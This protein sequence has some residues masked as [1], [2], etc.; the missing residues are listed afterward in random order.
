MKIKKVEEIK[1]NDKIMAYEVTVE[2]DGE[3]R[4]ECFVDDG[5][6]FDLVDGEEKF[7]KQ[8]K[9]NKEK[10]NNKVEEEPD[11]VKTSIK[12]FEDKVI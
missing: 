6:W 11:I 1:K 2:D 7:I 5:T 9:S 8:I 10:M 12:K 4:I 3:E